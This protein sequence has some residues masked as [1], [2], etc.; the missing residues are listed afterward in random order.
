MEG[1]A[2]L[3][4]SL[5]ILLYNVTHT[6]GP[7]FRSI[8]SVS[9][10]ILKNTSPFLIIS[11]HQICLTFVLPFYF[12]SLIYSY[13]LFGYLRRNSSIYSLLHAWQLLPV[14]LMD[15]PQCSLGDLCSKSLSVVLHLGDNEFIHISA[16]TQQILFP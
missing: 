2:L 4:T 5:L 13:A 7:S 14:L 1:S 8:T 16:F 3:P 6:R 11:E 12:T 10:D 15:C 9:T